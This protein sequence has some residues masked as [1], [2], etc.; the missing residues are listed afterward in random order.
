MSSSDE[1][2]AALL[3]DLGR[4]FDGF[5]IIDKRDD[6]LSH[7][8]DRALRLITLGGQDRYLTHYHTVIGDRLYVPD[9]WART[10][11]TQKIITLRHERV[12]DVLQCR[13]VSRHPFQLLKGVLR[14]RPG[15]NSRGRR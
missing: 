12:H 14:P 13:V 4:E 1:D 8:I 3:D 10:P 7:L 6:G 15:T 9:G 5:R 11:A 2:L